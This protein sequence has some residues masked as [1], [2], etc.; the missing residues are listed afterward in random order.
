MEDL[1]HQK[2]F[3]QVKEMQQKGKMMIEIREEKEK[4]EKMKLEENTKLKKLSQAELQAT[5]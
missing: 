2:E 5:S 3:T 4:I 1:K